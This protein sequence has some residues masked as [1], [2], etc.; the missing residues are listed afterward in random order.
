MKTY[1]NKTIKVIDQVICDVC[2]KVCTDDR[3][4]SEYGTL[5]AIWG[6]HSR[7]DGTKYEIQLCEN[8][9]YDTI[10]WMKN[11][12][13]EYVPIPQNDPLAGEIYLS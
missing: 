1:K 3:Y 4:Q 13:N 11:K 5:E 2:G 12:R 8:C 9:F 6:Y 7:N 10:S